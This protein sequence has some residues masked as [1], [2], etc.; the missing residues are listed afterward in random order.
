M[1]TI[2]SQTN[3]IDFHRITDA[4]EAKAKYWYERNFHPEL[5]KQVAL[6]SLLHSDP[7][8]LF[9]VTKV[10][11]YDKDDNHWLT[12]EIYYNIENTRY[13][14]RHISIPYYEES[15]A[16]S[17]CILHEMDDDGN[18]TDN[19]KSSLV[20]FS[21]HAMSQWIELRKSATTSLGKEI[22]DQRILI[23]TFLGLNRVHAFGLSPSGS[24][25]QEVTV[26][27]RCE[28]GYFTGR[29]TEEY[30]T[31]RYIVLDTFIQTSEAN[32][33]IAGAQKADARYQEYYPL[34]YNITDEASREDERIRQHIEDEMLVFGP[35]GCWVR[36][37]VYT[38]IEELAI[39]FR[40]YKD[41]TGRTP[42]IA[43]DNQ[44]MRKYTEIVNSITKSYRS[45]CLSLESNDEN[46]R[47][48]AIDT[49]IRSVMEAMLPIRILHMMP[50]GH[51]TNEVKLHIAK[52]ASEWLSRAMNNLPESLDNYIEK[53]IELEQTQKQ[54]QMEQKL[55]NDLNAV[56]KKYGLSK[57]F[58]SE[59]EKLHSVKKEAYLQL[60]ESIYAISR[61]I[62]AVDNEKQRAKYEQANRE[63]IQLLIEKDYCNQLNP[64]IDRYGKEMTL[65][66]ILYLMDNHMWDSPINHQG[67]K[68]KTDDTYSGLEAINEAVAYLQETY[69]ETTAPSSDGVSTTTD[70]EPAAPS[71]TPP[72]SADVPTSTAS[73]SVTSSEYT[74]AK[75]AFQALTASLHA[76]RTQLAQLGKLTIQ[77][78]LVTMLEQDNHRLENE[79]SNTKT[80]CDTI[81][82]DAADIASD[83]R[84]QLSTEKE[85]R[86]KA[87]ARYEETASAIRSELEKTRKQLEQ[88]NTLAYDHRKQKERAE[89]QLATLQRDYDTLKHNHDELVAKAK[90]AQAPRAKII[91]ISKLAAL[92]LM[93]KKMISILIPFLKTYGIVID[94][95]K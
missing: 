45:V 69:P 17:F 80:L 21:G 47:I 49:I 95:Y 77:D 50:K 36:G 23:V 57:K 74:Q 19:S 40:L 55:R 30:E 48:K 3:L 84:K 61:L 66:A 94:E 35:G 34:L 44:M 14:E 70:D 53:I 59:I 5:E 82:K 27:M 12:C 86:D 11:Y 7:P 79:L 78:E 37:D 89:Q 38:F 9:H 29:I 39:L 60:S 64:Y 8:M 20:R 71:T 18:L 41:L 28:D 92:P 25:P 63:W 15:G 54:R 88:S 81:T 33:D 73:T 10:S 31:Q 75:Q 90:E 85:K 52:L 32:A 62:P 91:P 1:D 51:V 68:T 22:E 67:L 4:V 65:R 72:S 43:K 16:Y 58:E 6:S 56:L 83:L 76:A 2:T 24:E 42:P 26:C 87:I 46:L 13:T 93:G